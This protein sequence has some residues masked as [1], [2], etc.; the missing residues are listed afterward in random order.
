MLRDRAGAE[1]V[2]CMA[3]GGGIAMTRTRRGTLQDHHARGERNGRADENNPPYGR[4]RSLASALGLLTKHDSRSQRMSNR[5]YQA[6]RKIGKSERATSWL[7]RLL[8]AVQRR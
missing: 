8:E 2:H 7:E 6:G 5:A 1:A 4:W 3:A